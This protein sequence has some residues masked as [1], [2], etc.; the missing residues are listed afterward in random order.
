MQGAC[1]APGRM[2]I[3]MGGSMGISMAVW[4]S[5]A[6]VQR[7]SGA[8]VRSREPSVC[9]CGWEAPDSRHQVLRADVQMGQATREGRTAGG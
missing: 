3:S 1:F 2:G 8:A 7:C 5:G 4:C 9:M 6:V